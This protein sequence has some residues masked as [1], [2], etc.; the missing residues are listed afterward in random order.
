[1]SPADTPI[2][3]AS[4]DTNDE[5]HEEWVETWC[6][7]LRRCIDDEAAAEDEPMNIYPLW[8]VMAMLCIQLAKTDSAMAHACID[9]FES[10]AQGRLDE[11]LALAKRR[12]H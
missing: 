7:S 11:H 10:D 12:D 6:E 1:M 5:D 4:P 9:V 8:R 2:E 3:A